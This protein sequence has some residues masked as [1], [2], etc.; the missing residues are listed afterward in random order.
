MKKV[1]IVMMALMSF[2]AFAK[3]ERIE[4]SASHYVAGLQPCD[5]ART[6]VVDDINYKANTGC[7]KIGG[8]FKRG[9]VE[10][11]DCRRE[12]ALQCTCIASAWVDCEI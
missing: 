12:S 10:N 1:L 4:V 6:R 9:A 3:V 2:D 5:K 8:I 11:L 7:Q